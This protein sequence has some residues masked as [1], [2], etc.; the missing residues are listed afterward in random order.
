[1]DPFRLVRF[2]KP[3]ST[4]AIQL[5]RFMPEG[6]RWVKSHVPV[7]CPPLLR[8]PPASLQGLGGEQATFEVRAA[9]LHAGDFEAGHFEA[10]TCWHG[11]WWL[12]DNA[13][14]VPSGSDALTGASADIYVVFYARVG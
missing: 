7:K 11:D 6:A 9:L 5:M 1:M 8:F 2:E 4:L 13:R 14:V 10:V 12:C 3:P